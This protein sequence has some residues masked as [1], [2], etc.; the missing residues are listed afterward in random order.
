MYVIV[1]LQDGE[2]MGVKSNWVDFGIVQRCARENGG[3][4]VVGG[5]GFEDDDFAHLGPNGLVL[6][7]W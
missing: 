2:G 3:K 1:E 7:W 5:I 6:E 4:D